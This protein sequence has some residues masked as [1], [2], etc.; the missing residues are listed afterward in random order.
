[1]STWKS[2]SWCKWFINTTA[3]CTSDHSTCISLSCMCSV[4]WLALCHNS[5]KSFLLTCL[6]YIYII[7]FSV[8]SIKDF[9]QTCDMKTSLGEHTQSLKQASVRLIFQAIRGS[10]E[11]RARV[12][13]DD[14]KNCWSV[15]IVLHSQMPTSQ[16]HTSP[17]HIRVF[18]LAKA[19]HIVTFCI[20]LGGI[21]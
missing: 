8:E 13:S 9:L 14:Q 10:S 2:K 18:E 7:Y 11:L 5:Q 6:N 15:W 21:L 17:S 3:Q 16:K 12:Y 4:T 1:M 19:Q 20:T